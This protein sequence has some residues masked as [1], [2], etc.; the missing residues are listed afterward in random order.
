MSVPF[1]WL[2]NWGKTPINNKPMRVLGID[3]GTTN[4]VVTDI[5]WDPSSGEAPVIS[6]LDIP[7]ETVDGGSVLQD[8]VPS[9]VAKLPNGKAIV[10]AG[11]HRLRVRPAE[12]E[13]NKNIWWDTKNL[14]GTRTNFIGA[15]EGFKIPRDIAAKILEFVKEG[16]DE[17]FDSPVDR[18]VVTVP[19]SFQLSQRLDTID[20]AKEAGISMQGGDL[21]D[22]PVAAF[23]DFISNDGENY[24]LPLGL[25]RFMV[26]DFGGG[27]C[28]V[29]LFEIIQ[30]APGQ[31]TVARKTVSRFHR[32]GGGDIDRT[33]ANDILLPKLLKQNGL[34]PKDITYREKAD[35]LL[36][37]LS[38]VAEQLKKSISSTINNKILLGNFDHEDENLIAKLPH[39]QEFTVDKNGRKLPFA[40]PSLTLTELKRALRAYFNPRQVEPDGSEFTQKT[41]IFTPIKETLRRAEWTPDHVDEILL[42]GGSSLFFMATDALKKYFPG[43]KLNRYSTPLE[44]QKSISRGAAIHALLLEAFGDSPVKPVIG[45]ELSIGTTAG[46]KKLIEVGEAL[47]F[48]SDGSFATF[49]GLKVPAFDSS[50]KCPLTIRLD[51]GTR[52]LHSK[53]VVL[54]SPIKSGDSIVLNYKIDENQ[55]LILKAKI[56]E[57]EKAVEHELD[58]D[59]PFSVTANPNADQDRILEIR[60]TI[61]TKTPAE[62]LV[63]F[64]ELAKLNWSVRNYE[65]ATYLYENLIN[66]TTLASKKNLYYEALAEIAEETHDTESQVEYLKKCIEFNSSVA[67][68]KIALALEKLERYEEAINYL[69]M[70]IQKRPSE[71]AAHVLK[72][73]LL[74]GLGKTTEATNEME[75]AKRGASNLKTVGKWE[76][77]WL[78]FAANQTKDNE[79]KK[80]ID[81][82]MKRRDANSGELIEDNG[83]ERL[84]DWADGN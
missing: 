66:Q 5:Q 17:I 51:S 75:I 24:E 48:P 10:G 70:F 64:E 63:L 35:Y 18:V 1:E 84:P 82:E 71:Y 14:I 26:V 8:L 37:A 32:L 76:L 25:T 55:R 83:N 49:T 38:S 65:Q 58:I 21:L 20:A 52:P 29:A 43:A 27:T 34:A 6:V 61:Q 39:T 4:S 22:E 73:R 57:G 59:N 44:T 30:A 47:P 2:K 31:I 23:L 19:A 53:E 56:G 36:P 45:E 77:W 54:E 16:A 12:F 62:Q 33:L 15:P 78:R 60:S 46:Q 3:L 50:G 9:V 42:V 68:F 40:E 11:A 69:N 7:Q 72:A 80:N 67:T 28:D 13:Q 81:A 79:F 41:S 74:T